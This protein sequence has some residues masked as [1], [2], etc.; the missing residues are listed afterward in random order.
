MDYIVGLADSSVSKVNNIGGFMK[1][2]LAIVLM[3][4][5]LTIAVNSLYANTVVTTA[6][7]CFVYSWHDGWLTEYYTPVGGFNLKYY[8]IYYCTFYTCYSWYSKHYYHQCPRC[9][10]NN[11]TESYY[12]IATSSIVRLIIN[13]KDCSV[14]GYSWYEGTIRNSIRERQ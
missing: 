9:N 1:K 3:I 4:F 10:Q 2:V 14:C 13:R 6:K 11:L 5:F 7:K 8:E 12:D